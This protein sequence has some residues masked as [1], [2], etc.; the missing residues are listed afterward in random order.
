[1]FRPVKIRQYLALMKAKGHT[2]E[3]VLAGSG[4]DQGRLADKDFLMEIDQSKVVVSNMIT[5][6]GDQGIGLE[7]GHQTELV[8]FGLVGHVMMSAR[9]AREAVQY[10]INYSNALIGMLIELKLE[11]RAADDWSLTISELQPLGFIYNF[12]VEEQ[13]VII[14]RLGAELTSVTPTMKQLDLSYPAPSHH[15]LYQQHFKGPIRFNARCTRISFTGPLLDQPLRGDDK[16]FN[17][18]CARQCELLMRQIG[19]QSPLVSKIQNILMRSRGRIP[20]I[21]TMARELNISARTLRRRL[22]DEDRSYQQLVNEF[23]IDMA[24]EYL[25]SV[26]V[27]TKEIAYLLGFRDTNSFRRAFKLWTGKTVQEYR[28][29]DR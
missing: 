3:A 18:M 11:E 12:C 1:M 4:V 9:S 6:T 16:E 19:Q 8:D 14:C 23:R 5:L 28:A 13:L 22:H 20:M 10:W 29:S 27:T 24:K 21:D 15:A 7:I 26:S 2:A 17:E 25:R